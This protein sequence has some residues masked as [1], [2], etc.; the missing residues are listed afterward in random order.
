MVILEGLSSKAATTSEFCEW[1][2]KTGLRCTRGENVCVAPLGNVY[3]KEGGL[4]AASNVHTHR[5][6]AEDSLGRRNQGGA[7]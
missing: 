2:N 5:I 3:G 4:L 1:L 6:T 7:S